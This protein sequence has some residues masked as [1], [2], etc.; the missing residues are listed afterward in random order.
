MARRRVAWLGVAWRRLGRPRRR[1]RGRSADRKR[2]CNTV[3]RIWI[4]LRLPLLLLRL[5]LSLLLIRLRLSVLCL[6]VWAPILPIRLR[7]PA[8]PTRICS[9]VPS[10][11]LRPPVLPLRQCRPCMAR[12]PPGG[13][14]LLPPRGGAL[15]STCGVN[16]ADCAWRFETRA[17]RTSDANGRRVDRHCR[18][19]PRPSTAPEI[20][21][22]ALRNCDHTSSFFA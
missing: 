8:L 11:R 21:P 15:L 5:R 17:K 6:R 2:A 13:A 1:P 16:V 14:P 3:L 20:F 12:P 7:S 9:S 22:A 10:V 18:A 19:G 4:R